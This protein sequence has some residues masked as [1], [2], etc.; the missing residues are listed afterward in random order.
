[1]KAFSG[2]EREAMVLTHT[3]DRDFP[4]PQIGSDSGSGG[5]HWDEGRSGHGARRLSV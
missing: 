2:L 5:K 1:M 3:N 4:V